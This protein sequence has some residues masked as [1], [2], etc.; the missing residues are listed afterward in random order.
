MVWPEDGEVLH[1]LL[2]LGK[3]IDGKWRLSCNK[4]LWAVPRWA[5]LGFFNDASPFTCGNVNYVLGCTEAVHL[6]VAI[7]HTDQQVKYANLTFKH[8]PLFPSFCLK[9][10]IFFSLF[11]SL[12][13]SPSLPQSLFHYVVFI[14]HTEHLIQALYMI[15]HCSLRKVNVQDECKLFHYFSGQREH[16]RAEP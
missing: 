7:F 10:P 8:K 15:A 4:W 12:S 6:L 1:C 5:S 2:V 13:F 9:I 3:Q 14:W 11:F 16:W